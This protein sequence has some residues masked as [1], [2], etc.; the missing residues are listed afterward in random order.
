MTSDSDV[1]HYIPSVYLSVIR[2]AAPPKRQ[3]KSHQRR[4]IEIQRGIQNELAYPSSCFSF[5]RYDYG[6]RF[7]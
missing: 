6:T 5:E 3:Y 7:R 4:I 1:I 2:T